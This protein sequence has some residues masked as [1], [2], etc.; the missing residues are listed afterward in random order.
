MLPPWV[1]GTPVSIDPRRLRSPARTAA[2][3]NAVGARL[4]SAC[5]NDRQIATLILLGCLQGA[6]ASDVQQEIRFCPADVARTYHLDSRARVQSLVLPH[7]AVINHAAAPFAV[8]AIHLELIKGGHLLDTR[9]LNAAD[10][11]KL[12]SNSSEIQELARDASFMFCGTELIGPGINLAGPVLHA[13]E[14]LVVT[15]EVFAFSGERDTL[16]VRVEGTVAGKGVELSATL[17]VTSKISK[18][19][20]LFPVRGVSYVGWGLA[21]TPRIVGYCLRRMH[22]ISPDWVGVA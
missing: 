17:P 6:V 7:I 3:G 14:G 13:K 2:G 4:L 20:W 9:H 5:F 8:D 16:R 1:Q 10:V 15:N 11:E 19:D 21:S 18:T 12:A 22:W